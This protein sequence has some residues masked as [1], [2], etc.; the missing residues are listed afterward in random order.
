MIAHGMT[1]PDCR[2]LFCFTFFFGY[3]DFGSKAHQI[4]TE[5]TKFPGSLV[6]CY[7]KTNLN[8]TGQFTVPFSNPLFFL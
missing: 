1:D 6:F 4:I 8:I 2:R 3:T 5:F 7:D